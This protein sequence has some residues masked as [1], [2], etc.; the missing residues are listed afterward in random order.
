MTTNTNLTELLNKIKNNEYIKYAMTFNEHIVDE[1]ES[2]MIN[3][4]KD[5]MDSI[6]VRYINI[7]IKDLYINMYNT[8]NKYDD[9]IS[10][11]K[12]SKQSAQIYINF[13]LE[14]NFSDW[15]RINKL[16]FLSKEQLNEIINT[17]KSNTN[18]STLVFDTN[19]YEFNINQEYINKYN[20]YYK[21]ILDEFLLNT[22][23]SINKLVLNGNDNYMSLIDQLCKYIPI[24]TTIKTI[25][26]HISNKEKVIKLLQAI[27]LNENIIN[28]N[29]GYSIDDITY[30]NEIFNILE[31]NKSIKH[32]NLSNNKITYI[33]E[34]L[35]KF[36]KNN[37]VIESLDLSNNNITIK[38]N[39]SLILE[40]VSSLS[41]DSIISIP[42]NISEQ[43]YN[44][45]IDA[46]NT[47]KSLR[48]LKL[49]NNNIYNNIK[50]SLKPECICNV[51]LWGN[52]CLM[53]G[54]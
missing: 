42:Y 51:S 17:I 1:I 43:K 19:V 21:I 40:G 52:P 3:K 2:E 54:I 48:K 13:E 28:L 10:F 37:T 15:I 30:I 6:K 9:Y 12:N 41:N 50:I 45:L 25:Q 5:R 31:S 4:F 29:F 27:N 23:N 36:I 39:F 53:C 35:I 14:L 34:P 47:T 33:V 32:L 46:I 7:S 26:L 20:E 44:E 24:N 11:L 8:C 16:V 38:T 49:D 22:D 18:I